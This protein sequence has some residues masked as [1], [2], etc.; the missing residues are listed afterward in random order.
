MIS[1]CLTTYNGAKHVKEQID[2]ILTQ[3]GENDEL[4]VSDDCSIDATISIISSMNDERIKV[5]MNEKNIGYTRNFER[6][7]SL[8]RG[9]I[10]FLS[11][12]DDVWCQNKIKTYLHY[13]DDYDI[14]VSDAMLI[15]EEGNLLNDSFFSQRNPQ[16]TIFGNLLKFGYL[17]CC[18]A[19]KREILMKALPFPSNSNLCTHD[20]WLFLI[21]CCFFKYKILEEKL[22]LYRRHINNISNGGLQNTTSILFKIHY[23]LYLIFHLICRIL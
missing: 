12:Q 11:D 19:F 6:T 15:N 3:L 2:S 8:A 13:F 20:N 5:F 22:L 9:D 21:G 14:I 17:G 1:V 16:K 4:I 23:R 18:M 7:L 10:I